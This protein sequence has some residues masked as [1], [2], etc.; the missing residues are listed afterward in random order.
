MKILVADDDLDLLGLVAYSL[1]Q[2]GI[3]WSRPAT[4]RVRSRPSRP[5]RRT[6]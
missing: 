3:S 6:S 4:A 5:S 1:G 2:A